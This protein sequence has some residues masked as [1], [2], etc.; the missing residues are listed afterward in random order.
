[1]MLRIMAADAGT[2][3][4]MLFLATGVFR[5]HLLAIDTLYGKAL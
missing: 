2:F 1:M 4:K 5:S 3:E